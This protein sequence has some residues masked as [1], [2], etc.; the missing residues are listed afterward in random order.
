MQIIHI[1]AF[2][3]NDTVFQIFSI[4][5]VLA[6]Q[7]MQFGGRIQVYDFFRIPVR[8]KNKLKKEKKCYLV[9]P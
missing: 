2:W 7:R 1:L 6:E 8:T 4:S 5:L 3:L 9:D